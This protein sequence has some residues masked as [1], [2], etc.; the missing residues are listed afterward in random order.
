MGQ[1]VKLHPLPKRD[2]KLQ[3]ETKRPFRIWNWN[4]KKH[5]PGRC[6]RHHQHALNGALLLAYW[7]K[8]RDAFEVID[9]RTGHLLAQYVRNPT[10]VKEVK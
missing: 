2:V 7:G 5:E 4:T 8:V 9:I 10:S 3:P 1:V 6:Y